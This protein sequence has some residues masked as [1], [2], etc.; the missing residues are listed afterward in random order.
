[1]KG[2]EIYQAWKKHR[3]Q[4]ELSK[5]FGDNIMNRIRQ[6]KRERKKPLVNVYGLIELIS[7]HPLAKAGAVTAG[8]VIG[9]VRIVFVFYAFLAS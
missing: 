9:F 1:M 2:K 4:V 3:S 5:N 7:V 6:Y 8:A